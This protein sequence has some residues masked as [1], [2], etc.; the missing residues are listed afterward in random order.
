[1]CAHIFLIAQKPLAEVHRQALE[2]L[3]PYNHLGYFP[4]VK[5]WEGASRH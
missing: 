4:A 3:N 1:M 5:G 2:L